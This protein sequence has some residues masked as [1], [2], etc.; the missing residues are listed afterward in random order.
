MI[1][2]V[3]VGGSQGSSERTQQIR[4]SLQDHC[5]AEKGDHGQPMEDSFIENVLVQEKPSGEFDF[6]QH[7]IEQ[8]TDQRDMGAQANPVSFVEPAEAHGP[9]LLERSTHDQARTGE[10]SQQSGPGRLGQ[11]G[12]CEHEAG[13]CNHAVPLPCQQAISPLRDSTNLLFTKKLDMPLMHT[14]PPNKPSRDIAASGQTQ[15]KRRSTRL[16]S[17]PKSD[18]TMEQQATAL[19]MRKCG[20]GDGE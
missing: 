13:A 10:G 19:L 14:P 16:A 18:L 1:E 6:V 4:E 20:V 8:H 15:A 9:T 17:R 2:E 7:E 5:I 3:K 12:S 11:A